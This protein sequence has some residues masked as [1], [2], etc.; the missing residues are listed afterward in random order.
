S[1]LIAIAGA[2]GGLAVGFAG[3]IL[4]R[5]YEYP[6]DLVAVPRMELDQRALVFSLILAVVSAFLFGLAPALQTTRVDLITSL[7]AGDTA[8]AR[9]QRLAGRNALVALQVA[10]SLVL[11][12][13]TAFALDVFSR[14]IS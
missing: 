14:E 9:R 6:V 5:Q 8:P 1:L 7:K 2:A 4:L 10:A 13:V 3:I 12:T 11:L